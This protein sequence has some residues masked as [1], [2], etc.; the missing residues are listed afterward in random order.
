MAK[1]LKNIT[2]GINNLIHKKVKIYNNVV[3]GNNNK[4][5]EGTI[6]YPNTIIGDN[7]IILNGNILGE[8]PIE[9]RDNFKDKVF[10][11]LI[12]GN[13]NFFHVNNIIFNGYYDKTIIG[14]NNKLLSENHIGH[15]TNITN[16]VILYP[17]CITGGLSKLMPFSTMGMYSCIQQNAVL[18]HFS[19]IGMGNIAS[20]NVFPFFIYANNKYLRLNKMK[21]PENLEIEKYENKLLDLIN[22]L[23]KNKFDKNTL[24]N[25]DLPKEINYYLSDFDDKIKIFK[26]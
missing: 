1:N 22:N 11:G 18:G 2:I 9:T 17:R 12:I 14:D 5:Y 13:N 4:I 24:L 6:I 21:I 15:D 7:N 20:H 26:I 19:M 3:I 16:N 10:N 8:H 25:N 23:K